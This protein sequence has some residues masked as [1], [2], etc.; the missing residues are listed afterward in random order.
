MHLQLLRAA[1]AGLVQ[2]RERTEKWKT[3]G[4]FAI[5]GSS[6]SVERWNW[7]ERWNELRERE[8][9]SDITSLTVKCTW[10]GGREADGCSPQI[11]LSLSSSPYLTYFLN[12]GHKWHM[13]PRVFSLSLKFH[14]IYYYYYFF[15]FASFCLL[16]FVS[17]PWFSLKWSFLVVLWR[18]VMNVTLTGLCWWPAEDVAFY[19]VNSLFMDDVVHR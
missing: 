13:L 18:Y 15:F 4:A 3:R 12:A 1:A 7:G 14:F 8:S 5:K 6:F 19:Y 2:K 17:G 10:D 11:S 9:R 16:S